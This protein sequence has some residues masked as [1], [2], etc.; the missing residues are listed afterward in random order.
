MKRQA[1][2]LVLTAA[3]LLP[4]RA[5]AQINESAPLE[6][7]HG[8]TLIDGTGGPPIEDAALSVRGNGI[9]TVGSRRELLAGP[10]APSQAG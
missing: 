10:A 5:D 9:V 2:L 3:V 6:I 1:I 4:P 7:Y 8:F